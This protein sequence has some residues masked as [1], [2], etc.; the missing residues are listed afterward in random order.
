MDRR[1]Q[2]KGGLD[3]ACEHEGATARESATTRE[4]GMRVTSRDV[5]RSWVPRTSRST[6]AAAGLSGLADQCELGAMLLL[7]ESPH[8]A[9]SLGDEVTR[10][11]P[12]R[13]ARSLGLRNISAF[14]PPL[15]ESSGHP[16]KPSPRTT[17]RDSRSCVG[18]A[19]KVQA[20]QSVVFDQH[21]PG[22]FE[23]EELEP[24]VLLQVVLNECVPELISGRP[25]DSY[26]ERWLRPGF[27]SVALVHW[28]S[29]SSHSPDRATIGSRAPFC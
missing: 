14:R 2:Y 8:L 5:H 28:R 20:E 12:L 10:A 21:R 15:R 26:W 19:A 7:A 11:T 23:H 1:E 24:L 3:G 22:V 29:R 16:P 25:R 4:A 9:A 13:H 6:S 17:L 27:N 18:D